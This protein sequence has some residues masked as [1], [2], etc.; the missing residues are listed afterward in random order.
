MDTSQ[1]R[2]SANELGNF[3]FATAAAKQRIL[4]DQKFPKAVKVARYHAASSAVLRC[5]QNGAFSKEELLKELQSL[6]EKSASTQYQAG[7][8]HANIKALKRF[9]TISEKAAP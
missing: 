3:V 1:P 9:L 8:Q 6:Q 2:I 7:I 4:R 5:L